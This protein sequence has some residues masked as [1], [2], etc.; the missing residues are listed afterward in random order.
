MMD[1]NSPIGVFDSGVGGISVLKVLKEELPHE[2]FIFFGDSKHAP[3]GEKRVDEIRALSEANLNFL[4]EK[5][6]KAVVIACNTATSAAAEYLRQKYPDYIIIGMEPAVKPAAKIW[7]EQKP[8][9][10]VM[11]TPATIEGKRLSH[12]LDLHRGDANYHLLPAPKIV[13]LVE[14]GLE[15]SHEM[16]QY[17]EDIL[18]PY[19]KKDDGSIDSPIHSLVL[20]CTHFPFVKK[21]I[22]EVMGYPIQF[23]DG[24]YGTA[25]ETRRRLK[26]SGLLSDR[27]REGNIQ[28][29][30][31][32]GSTEIPERLLQLPI[33]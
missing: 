31:S 28:L 6:A 8:E 21:Q 4:L 1:K 10:L 16:Y 15:N 3:Y 23:F 14:A 27:E 26:V 18:S 17:L 12:L 2:D 7:H 19:R 5:G 30:S 22:Q 20:G 24:A 13:R 29:F 33:S 11:A 25:R 32:S 9:V